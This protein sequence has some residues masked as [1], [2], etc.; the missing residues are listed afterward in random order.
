MVEIRAK[1]GYPLLANRRHPFSIITC[2]QM[3]GTL[4]PNM[5]P[6]HHDKILINNAPLNI[7]GL[8]CQNRAGLG[9]H[10]EMNH[11]HP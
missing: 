1:I 5:D 10:T 7:T 11:G 3:R 9:F 2:I 4:I 6:I 8:P